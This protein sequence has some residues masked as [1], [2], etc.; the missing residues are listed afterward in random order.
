MS[1]YRLQQNE[2]RVLETDE[3]EYL[4][5]QLGREIDACTEVQKPYRNKVKKFLELKEIWHISEIDYQLRAR[6]EEFI[7][8]EITA[9]SWSVYL[10]GFD[11]I[12][13]HFI[14]EEMQTLKG[15]N[16]GKLKYENKILFLP[17]HPE[18]EI[19]ML[20]NRAIDNKEELVW[21]FSRKASKVMKEQIFTALHYIIRQ[22]ANKK[23]RK[24]NLQA[25]RRFYDFCI[26]EQ[27]EDIETI[28]L[29]LIQKFKGL[30]SGKSWQKDA[31]GVVDISRKAVFLEADEIHWNANVWYLDRFHFE[32]TRIN[33]SNPVHSLSFAE[34]GHMGNR[35]LLQQY[36]KY[37]LGITHLSFSSLSN[38]L[39][40]VRRFMEYLDDRAIMPRDVC[41]IDAETIGG[42]FRSRDKS[43]IK[44]ESYNSEVMAVLRFFDYLH[45]KEKIARGPFCKEYYL[46]KTI[47]KH[48]DRS[49]AEQVCMEI[50]G[51]LHCFPEELRLMFLH[52]WGIGLRASEV[53]TLKGNAYYVQGRDAWIKVYQIK[54]KTYKQIPIP[55]ALYRLMK[56]FIKKYGIKAEDYVFQN[57][58]G[59]AYAYNTFRSKMKKYCDKNQIAGGEY[60]FQSHDYR[61][62]VATVF[63]DSGV[64]VQGVRDYL[65]HEYEEMTRQYIDY[66]PK[67]ISM[68]S[69]EYFAEPENSLGTGV[70]RCRRGE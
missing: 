3:R 17:Y 24:K 35:R 39:H 66:M 65:G 14:R 6:Y 42:Y 43:G 40:I 50:L 23:T 10:R 26:K 55:I 1:A 29:D 68:A 52:L 47:L 30:L 51:K 37:G 19:A 36:M 22:Y 53:C 33:P 13:Q 69:E 11:R 49:V 18:Q 58:K 31:K 2:L 67:K 9:V 21:D 8:T 12:K 25:L 46:K 45:V 48:H 70:K 15:R 59:G 41:S 54:M 34:V 61:H 57:K 44:D 16:N 4:L 60:L 20:Y 56:V 63:Y 7:K 27:V 62:T 38:E 32:S 5:E 28:E 64:S